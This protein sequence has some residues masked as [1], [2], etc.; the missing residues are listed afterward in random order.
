MAREYFSL[1]QVEL[2]RRLKKSMCNNLFVNEANLS[3]TTDDSQN[4][5]A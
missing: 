4:H 2:L 1:R 5:A 3:S